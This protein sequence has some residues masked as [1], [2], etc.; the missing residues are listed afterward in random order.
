VP[1]LDYGAP[2]R[3]RDKMPFWIVYFASGAAAIFPTDWLFAWILRKPSGSGAAMCLGLWGLIVGAIILG[4]FR[5]LRNTPG[6]NTAAAVAGLLAPGCGLGT[7]L[8]LYL[9]WK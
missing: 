4:V 5:A 2:E 1:A 6:S 9:I 7:F 8:L 3:E